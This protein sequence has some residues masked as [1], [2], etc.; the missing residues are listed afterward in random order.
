MYYRLFLKVVL[1]ACG[2]NSLKVYVDQILTRQNKRKNFCKT[3]S[4]GDYKD[5]TNIQRKSECI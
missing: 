5:K 2:R 3:K 4:F 1:V